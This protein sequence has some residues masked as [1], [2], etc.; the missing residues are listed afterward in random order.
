MRLGGQRQAA[1]AGGGEAAEAGAQRR[2]AGDERPA[3]RIGE[4]QRAEAAG[5]RHADLGDDER[6]VAA[7]AQEAAEQRLRF[8]RAVGRGDVE[9]VDAGVEGGGERV[10]PVGGGDP[11]AERGAAEAEA[12]RRDRRGGALGRVHRRSSAGMT[13]TPIPSSRK[14]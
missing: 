11:R 3:E 6:A 9:P 5:R 4:P 2:G 7:A 1:V 8:A 13:S 12:R 10:E 14:T